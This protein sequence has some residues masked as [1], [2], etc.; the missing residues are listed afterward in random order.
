MKLKQFLQENNVTGFGII[1]DTLIMNIITDNIKRQ[2][3][4]VDTSNIIAGTQLTD[5]SDFTVENDI[6]TVDTISININ[7]I[8]IFIP[9]VR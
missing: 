7:E 1:K 6:L 9:P 4:D 8:D 5:I 3:L 2:R